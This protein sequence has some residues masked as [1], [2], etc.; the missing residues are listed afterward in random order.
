MGIALVK[1]TPM[2]R[3][4]TSGVYKDDR[5]VSFISV[6]PAGYKWQ[7][8]NEVST[9]RCKRF[10]GSTID[11]FLSDVFRDRTQ[12][13]CVVADFC[14]GK[15]RAVQL[16]NSIRYLEASPRLCKAISDKE[17][18]EEEGNALGLFRLLFAQTGR[19]LLE[20][21]MT[22]ATEGDPP[23]VQRSADGNSISRQWVSGIARILATMPG[24]VKAHCMAYHHRLSPDFSPFQAD[25]IGH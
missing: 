2:G 6:P 20:P 23:F 1:H 25:R 22:K 21:G 18:G 16:W 11:D 9:V 8:M 14:S 24:E 10:D 3:G 12:R 17:I 4:K 7:V 15:G 19:L 5:P 13:P